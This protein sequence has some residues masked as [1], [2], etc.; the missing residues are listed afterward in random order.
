MSTRVPEPRRL[1]ARHEVGGAGPAAAEGELAAQPR[2]GAAE[3]VDQQREAGLVGL[4]GLAGGLAGRGDLRGGPVRASALGLGP[5]ALPLAF[6]RG[7][8]DPGLGL[9]A[10]RRHLLFGGR[11]GVERGAQRGALLGQA[12]AQLE[13]LGLALLARLPDLGAGL[14]QLAAQ[15]L[16]LGGELVDLRQQRVPLGLDLADLDAAG[17]GRHRVRRVRV[18]GEHGGGRVVPAGRRP[19]S[20][21]SS[22]GR[23]SS[24]HA[25]TAA[26]N[27][28]DPASSASSAG[29]PS[30]ARLA[31]VNPAMRRSACGTSAACMPP[32]AVAAAS[33]S[34]ARSGSGSAGQSTPPGTPAVSRSRRATRTLHQGR[35]P[36]PFMV[37]LVFRRWSARRCAIP[38]GV[39][40]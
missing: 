24:H 13:E 20:A 30:F 35:R 36:G 19:S 38:V 37:V 1:R 29:P 21:T 4:A 2:D 27:A 7:R 15:P 9:G 11:A 32:T 31:G 12:P 40:G 3:R 17:G 6:G 18:A 8:G 23:C 34:R 26:R 16:Q 10:Q 5:A 25:M 22:P 33:A 14:G 28:A 39:R